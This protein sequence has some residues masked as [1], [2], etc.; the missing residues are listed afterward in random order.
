[1]TGMTGIHERFGIPGI[2]GTTR[3]TER[4]G[5]LCMPGMCGMREIT[6][7]SG[8]HGIRGMPGMF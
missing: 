8:M 4:T 1:M 2:S 7:M 6:V 5:M 3:I